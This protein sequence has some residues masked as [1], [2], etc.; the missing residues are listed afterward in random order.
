MYNLAAL[1]KAQG[2]L[3]EATTLFRRELEGCAAHLGDEHEETRESARN[4]AK[5]VDESGGVDEARQLRA[6]FRI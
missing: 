1:L 4:L 3:G 5:L 6:R 2:K